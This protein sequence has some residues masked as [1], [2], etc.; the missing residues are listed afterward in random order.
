[1][2]VVH[3]ADAFFI[4]DS[5]PHKSVA[6]VCKGSKKDMDAFYRNFYKVVTKYTELVIDNSAT[7][8]AQRF[9]N[10]ETETRYI[11]YIQAG[12]L[13]IQLNY[14]RTRQFYV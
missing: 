13:N 5:F 4:D 7:S 9:N 3:I 11:K 2:R 12:N 14:F 8:L 1:M 10:R 6:F